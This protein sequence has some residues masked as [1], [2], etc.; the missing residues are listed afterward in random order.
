M[1]EGESQIKKI[2][3]CLTRKKCILVIMV[4]Y[5]LQIFLLRVMTSLKARIKFILHER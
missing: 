1:N 3:I 5:K 4:R 2:N